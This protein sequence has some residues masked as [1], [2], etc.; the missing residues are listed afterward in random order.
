[1]AT[2]YFKET[3]MK[4]RSNMTFISAVLMSLCLLTFIP[5]SLRYASTFRELYFDWPCIK[6]ENFLMPL[7]FYSLGFVMIGL[8]VLW[9]G[10]R[11]KERWALFVMLII[12][13]CYVFPLNILRPLMEARGPSW[14]WSGWLQGIHEGYRPG[15]W[16]AVGF[17]TFLVMLFALLL[18]IKE[19]FWRQRGSW[20][21]SSHG[22]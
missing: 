8:I 21:S 9:T 4:V 13:F 19:F 16:M 15:I 11:K 7:G 1:M 17:I 18:P 22:Q 6:E 3:T 5:A 10:Y 2:H 20:Q 12:L 14:D